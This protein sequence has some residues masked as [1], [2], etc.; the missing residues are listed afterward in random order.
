MALV[1]I[2]NFIIRKCEEAKINWRDARVRFEQLAKK[3]GVYDL[4][5]RSLYKTKDDSVFH[6]ASKQ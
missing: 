3:F 1:D 2:E 6:E 4:Y 5:C